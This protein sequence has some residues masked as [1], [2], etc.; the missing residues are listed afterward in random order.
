MTAE[1]PSPDDLLVDEVAQALARALPVVRVASARAVR[2]L[3]REALER[4]MEVGIAVGHNPL[5]PSGAIGISLDARP[6]FAPNDYSGIA[7]SV[8]P[9]FLSGLRPGPWRRGSWTDAD[10]ARAVVTAVT[11][12][13]QRF[14]DRYGGP[15]PYAENVK[16]EVHDDAIWVEVEEVR[17]YCLAAGGRHL[18]GL[19]LLRHV[20][21]AAAWTGRSD[22]ED[23]AHWVR[24][25]ERAAVTLRLSADELARQLDQWERQRL[26]T[27]GLGGLSE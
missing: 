16:P 23:R 27:L 9:S 17:A 15:L 18:D 24:V 21:E 14:V 19:R 26:A 7:E 1:G 5:W 4:R 3:H 11:S 2:F 6:V 13:L 8:D 25:Q 20:V 22:A 10:V 12:R